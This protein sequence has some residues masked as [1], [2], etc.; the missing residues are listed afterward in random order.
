[1]DF[2]DVGVIYLN[3]DTKSRCPGC[4]WREW[5]TK[6]QCCSNCLTPICALYRQ[7]LFFAEFYPPATQAFSRIT[8][9]KSPAA[10][11]LANLPGA[12]V[13]GAGIP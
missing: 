8:S 12:T 4:L 9:A 6:K 1:M 3:L 7:E 2:R 10:A 13:P 11:G 5:D